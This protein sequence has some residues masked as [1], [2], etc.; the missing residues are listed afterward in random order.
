MIQSVHA[1]HLRVILR[2]NAHEVKF[3]LAAFYIDVVV[4]IRSYADDAVGQAADHF[5]EKSCAHDDGAGLLNVCADVGV[6]AF[7]QVVSC[8]RY[9]CPCL[10]Q[11]TFKGGNGAFGC[12]CS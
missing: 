3:A 1:G 8:N 2:T 7:L 6:Y 9:V 4:F 5:A 11:Q 12:G 10:D